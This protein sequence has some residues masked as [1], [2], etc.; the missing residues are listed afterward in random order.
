M[1]MRLNISRH[2][3]DLQDVLKFDFAIPTEYRGYRTLFVVW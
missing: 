3:F 1:E 2:F